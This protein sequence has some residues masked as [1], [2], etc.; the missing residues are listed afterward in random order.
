M[1]IVT[2]PKCRKLYDPGMDDELEALGNVASVKV[3]CP[4]CGQ[5]L[6]LPENEAIPAPPLP[7]DMLKS[8]MWQSRL[9]DGNSGETEPRKRVQRRP[10]WKFW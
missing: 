10:W 3:V 6:R 2:C 9:V 8:M 1:P 4:A 5:W 7:P